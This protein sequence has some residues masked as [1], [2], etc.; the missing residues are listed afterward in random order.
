ML[1]HLLAAG[2]AILCLS[3]PAAAQQIADPAYAPKLEAPAYTEQG[4]S[5]AI[6]DAH[7]NFHTLEGRYA[8]F[9]KLLE[10]DGYKVSALTMPLSAEALATVT[11]LVIGNAQS[12]PPETSAFTLEEIAA[13]HAWVEAGGSLLLLADHAPYGGAAADLARSFGVEMGQGY[14]AAHQEGKVTFAIDY[15]GQQLGDHVIFHGR[16]EKEEVRQVRTFT[17]QSLSVPDGAVALLGLPADAIEVATPLEAGA[18]LKGETPPGRA[19]GGRAQAVAMTLGKGRVVIAG[20][21]AMFSAQTV[22]RPNQPIRYMGLTVADDQQFAL[23]TLH[24]LSHLID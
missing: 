12:A 14:V 2:A 17:G 8:P 3:A 7:R 21:A 11:V 5:V 10:A 4:P 22:S 16:S 13:T 1:K 24:W 15:S 20:E 23:N 9:G 6:D 19:M 18:L